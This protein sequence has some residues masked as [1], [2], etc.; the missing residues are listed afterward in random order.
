MT[1]NELAEFITCKLPEQFRAN[2][3]S[4]RFNWDFD[5]GGLDGDLEAFTIRYD[6]TFDK[7]VVILE[8]KS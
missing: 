6:N 8:F 3:V 4:A 7:E 2:E 1:Y 5:D